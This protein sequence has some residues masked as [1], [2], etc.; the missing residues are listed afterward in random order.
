MKLILVKTGHVTSHSFMTFLFLSWRN[1]PGRIGRL[2]GLAEDDLSRK[3]PKR[4]NNHTP[5]KPSVRSNRRR[6]GSSAAIYP[7][8]KSQHAGREP[9]RVVAAPARNQSQ[10]SN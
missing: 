4:E 5:G 7:H 6:N 2:E 1:N 10:V 8:T 9:I 3:S